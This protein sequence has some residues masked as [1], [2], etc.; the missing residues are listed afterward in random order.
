MFRPRTLSAH[1]IATMP[2]RAAPKAEARVQRG[3][4]NY[5]PPQRGNLTSIDFLEDMPWNVLVLMRNGEILFAGKIQAEY[6]GTIIQVGDQIMADNGEVRTVTP[7]TS[8]C[9]KECARMRP[10]PRLQAQRTG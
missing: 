10:H 2:R 4:L 5:T 3:T 9:R 1:S 7:V 6:L 8:A